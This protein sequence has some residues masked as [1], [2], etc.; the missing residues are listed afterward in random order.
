RYF[1]DQS[2]GHSGRVARGQGGAGTR[3]TRPARRRWSGVAGFSGARSLGAQILGQQERFVMK[4]SS[5]LCLPPVRTA[6]GQFKLPG[7]KSISNRVLLLAALA[8][9][10]T[11][12]EGLLDS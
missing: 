3:R 11:E 5:S 12:L 2:S 7:S 8:E 4:D 1:P 6:S 10:V 9:G